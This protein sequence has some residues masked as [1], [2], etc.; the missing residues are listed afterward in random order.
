MSPKLLQLTDLDVS[1]AIDEARGT[2]LAQ[3]KECKNYKI[4]FDIDI[5]V[6]QS[7]MWQ[8]MTSGQR[9]MAMKFVRE[10]QGLC[11]DAQAKTT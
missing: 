7:D 3:L 11:N 1:T 2:I 5:F 9:K 4:I 10:I 8:K 6:K